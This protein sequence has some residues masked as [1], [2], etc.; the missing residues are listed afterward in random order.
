MRKYVCVYNYFRYFKVNE[1]ANQTIIELVSIL[2]KNEYS[3]L[4][5]NA[6]DEESQSNTIMVI[7]FNKRESEY[8]IHFKYKFAFGM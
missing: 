4:A 5:L 8:N 1:L 7:S 6:V 2:D 3:V